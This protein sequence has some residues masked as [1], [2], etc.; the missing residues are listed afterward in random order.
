MATRLH[1]ISVFKDLPGPS[2]SAIE[3]GAY[4]QA[5]D[6]LTSVGHDIPKELLDEAAID[7]SLK[8]KESHDIY[9]EEYFGRVR[10]VGRRRKK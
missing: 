8:R 2:L 6:Y 9:F 4:E 7:Q 10:A 1:N 3:L 5:I